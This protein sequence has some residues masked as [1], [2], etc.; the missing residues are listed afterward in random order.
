M[1][2]WIHVARRK[3]RSPCGEVSLLFLFTRHVPYRSLLYIRLVAPIIRQHALCRI[4]IRRISVVQVLVLSRVARHL[5]WTIRESGHVGRYLAQ[6]PIVQMRYTYIALSCVDTLLVH[7]GDSTESGQ[8]ADTKL[9]RVLW[10]VQSHQE[11]SCPGIQTPRCEL[12]WFGSSRGCISS[13]Q[14]SN[15]R[16]N[17]AV[18]APRG[19]P[20]IL[21]CLLWLKPR[22]LYFRGLPRKT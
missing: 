20:N 21:P 4:S 9:G 3:V 17:L 18:P 13:A 6:S 5:H 8:D 12:D 11:K 10:A 7:I 15:A 14:N 2:G 16:K 19:Q 1:V 22:F